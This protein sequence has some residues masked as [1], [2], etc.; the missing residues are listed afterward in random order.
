[1]VWSGLQLS[2]TIDEIQ[3]ALQLQYSAAID[4][5]RWPLEAALRSA[6]AAIGN[7]NA[8]TIIGPSSR[9][10]LPPPVQHQR[11]GRLAKRVVRARRARAQYLRSL[12]AAG[13]AAAAAVAELDPA[14]RHTAA[15]FCAK[16]APPPAEA[17]AHSCSTAALPP[18]PPPRP[19]TSGTGNLTM[20]HINC[21]YIQIDCSG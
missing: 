10:A 7:I 15:T 6:A 17:A 18:T 19:S 3:S 11:R 9:P 14:G 20:V 16:L 5:A 13:G 8:D 12:E 1:M 4:A 21:H 2:L